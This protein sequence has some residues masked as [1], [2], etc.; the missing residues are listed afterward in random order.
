MEMRKKAEIHGVGF[1]G[2]IAVDSGIQR[3]FTFDEN[4]VVTFEL[5]TL[6]ASFDVWRLPDGNFLYCHLGPE[7]HGAR[8]V[9][10]E[11]E[12]VTDYYSDSEIFC[13]QP[14]ADGC[15]LTGELTEKRL[16]VVSP[17]GKAETVIPIKSDI[18]GHEVMRTAR[19]LPDGNYLVVHPGDRVIRR[20]SE[21]GELLHETPTRNDTFAATETADGHIL[22]TAQ[23][24]VVEVTQAGEELWSF[25]KEDAPSLG[26]H[27]LTGMVLCKDG[28]IVL[29]N[30]LGHGMEGTGTPLFALSP[31]RAI[32]WTF[33][34]PSFT[35]NLAN[36]KI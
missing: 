28:G 13:C 29:C 12:V 22:Y 21:L 32:M 7:R 26:I 30:W 23:T 24:A 3:I 14:L 33:Q 36:M 9:T 25:G 6:G 18:S 8:V 34:A 4:G 27:W 11:N 20:Y 15:I 5:P 10:S 17:L 19:R 2:L 35:A 16:V 1:P 31:D